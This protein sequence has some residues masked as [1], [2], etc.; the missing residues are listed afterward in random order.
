MWWGGGGAGRKGPS[1]LVG[2]TWQV[3]P[4]WNGASFLVDPCQNYHIDH[5]MCSQCINAVRGLPVGRITQLKTLF[6]LVLVKRWTHPFGSATSTQS[7]NHR[8]DNTIIGSHSNNSLSSVSALEQKPF[9]E[10]SLGFTL[11]SELEDELLRKISLYD[12]DLS[13]KTF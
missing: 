9:L 2:S 11:D 1:A 8:L 6:S 3:L 4:G 13:D 5:R 7:C 10:L 12:L